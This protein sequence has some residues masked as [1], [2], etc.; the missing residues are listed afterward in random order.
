MT[1]TCEQV[2]DG[3]LKIGVRVTAGI[4]ASQTRNEDH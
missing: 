4:A 1:A 3:M 2:T